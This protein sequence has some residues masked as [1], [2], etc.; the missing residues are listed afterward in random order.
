MN[1]FKLFFVI[2]IGLSS[3]APAYVPNVINTRLLSNKGDT[4]LNVNSGFS[5]FDPQ[6]AYALT[7]NTG[8]LKATITAFAEP[9]LTAKMGYKYIKAVFQFDVSIPFKNDNN[10]IEYNPIL[11]SFGLQ[12]S[13]N[14][15]FNT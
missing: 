5:G 9:A 12:L 14:E 7:D 15:L 3:C 11:L 13:F 1:L 2:V 6:F 10:I 8:I 4:R